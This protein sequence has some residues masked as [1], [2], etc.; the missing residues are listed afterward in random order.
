MS[1]PEFE[2]ILKEVVN[3]KRLSASKMTNLTDIA[4][5]NMEHDTQLV[6]ILYRTHKSLPN[7]SA[8]VSSL[9][10]FDA[11]SRAAKHH[12]TKHGLSG[13]AFTQPGNSASFLFKVGGVVEGLFQDMVTSGSMESKEKTKKILDI[14]VKGNTFP[15]T[16]LSQ[17]SDILKGPQKVPDVSTPAVSVPDSNTTTLTID[18]RSNASTLTV[19]P[20]TI[21]APY[22]P[23]PGPAAGSPPI[24]AVDPQ[25]TLLALLTQAAASTA[26]ISTP[27]TSTNIGIPPQLDAAQLAVIQQLAHTAASVPS[28][29]QF[30]PPPDSVNVQKFPSSSGVNGSSHSPPSYRSEPRVMVESEQRY[31]GYRS[32]ESKT[33]PDPLF[34][35][36]DNMRGRYRG[37]FRNRGRGDRFG[38]AW[39]PRDRDHY[40]ETDR[41]QSPPRTGRGGRSRS[42]SPPS[43]YAG[44][45]GSRYSSPP[46][47]PSAASPPS[48]QPANA[49]RRENE[50]GKDEF[51]RDI[52]PESPRSP[53]VA[54]DKSPPSAP[55][56]PTH[57]EPLRNSRSPLA[58]T[59]NHDSN[60]D[61]NSVSSLVTANTSSTKP[62]SAPLVTNSTAIGLGME[63]FNSSLFDY[64]SPAAWEALGKMWQV[65]HGYLPSTEELMQFVMTSGSAQPAPNASLSNQDFTKSSV[66]PPTGRGR[67]RGRDKGGFGG[68]RGGTMYGNGRTMQE[69]SWG[70]DDH[71]QAT[72]A[73]V[74]GEG[75]ASNEK[76]YN[77]TVNGG[78]IRSPT[79]DHGPTGSSAGGRMQR[80]GDKWVFV[81]G[82]PMDVS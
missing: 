29:P 11:L 1:L 32:P 4:M 2:A 65:T 60:H 51:G 12:A 23:P 33:R 79:D 56:S 7:T 53:S 52:R 25:A 39:D 70:Y 19:D 16:I 18:P 15:S 31:S 24:P 58:A 44:R 38:R 73:V 81:R 64:T 66:L 36:Q 42:R 35:E 57:S 55:K 43:R 21:P 69:D 80:V 17:L 62:A 37:G 75:S 9:Y 8:K 47:R 10:I 76:Q 13:D 72:D 78:Q 34:D 59:T 26:N 6:S 40:K 14:W 63:N 77:N 22:G 46:R 71:S 61:S 41:D 68:G 27:Q 74:L 48:W 30:L 28:V 49:A 20:R 5:K 54:N 45:K 3:A 50:P 82:T 67:G